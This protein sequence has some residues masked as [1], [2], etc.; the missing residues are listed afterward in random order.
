MEHLSNSPLATNFICDLLKIIDKSMLVIEAEDRA[1]AA[2]LKSEFDKLMRKCD[3]DR[4]YYT[5]KA[6]R[7]PAEISTALQPETVPRDLSIQ[8]LDAISRA[9]VTI[10]TRLKK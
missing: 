6:D 5:A 3:N 1:R 9:S 8:A 10:P 7:P 2:T 4:S